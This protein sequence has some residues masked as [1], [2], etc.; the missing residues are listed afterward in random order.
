[1]WCCIT[2]HEVCHVYEGVRVQSSPETETGK[3]FGSAVQKVTLCT[4]GRRS[5]LG[6]RQSRNTGNANEL[7]ESRAKYR[8]DGAKLRPSP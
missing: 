3:Q 4:R 1:M 5:W 8:H 6:F 2:L 7:T